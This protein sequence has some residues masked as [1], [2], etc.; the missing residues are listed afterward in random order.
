MENTILSIP[1]SKCTGC[2]ACGN[3]CPKNAITMEPDGE[4]FLFPQVNEALCI[5]CGKCRKVCPVGENPF[6]SENHVEPECYAMWAENEIRAKS[7]SGGVFTL[8]GKWAIENGGAVA[9]AAYTP[10]CYSVAHQI[11]ETEAELAPLRGSKYVQSEMGMTYRQVKE[12]LQADR[13][14]LFTGCPCQ[15][16][17]L[18]KFLGKDYQ[19]L[20][21]VELVC[22]GV[23]A[24]SI[25]AKFVKEQEQVVG[26]KAQSVNMRDKT[27]AEW[28]PAM[29]IH[30]A[31]GKKGEWKRNQSSY[32]RAFLNLLD[33]RPSCGN[34][35][36]AKLPRVADL[37]IADF[38][39]VHRF[40][41]KLDDRKGTSAVLVNNEKGRFL[42]SKIKPAAKLC[43]PVPL[44]H[45]IK[46]NPQIKYSSIHNKKRARFYSLLNEYHYP[47]EKAADYAL[48][49][50]YDIGY[51][52]WWYGLNYGSALTSFAMNRVLNQM[53]KTVLMLDFPVVNG[54]VPEKK[55]ATFTRKF[56]KHYYDEAPLTALDDY[57]KYNKMCDTFLVGSDQLWNWWSNRD[58]KTYFYF[59]DFAD[60]QHKKIAY[61]TSFGHEYVYYPEEMKLKVSYLLQRFDAISLREKSGVQTCN[62]DFNVEG[63][64]AID[65][66]FL[67][68]PRHYEE[69]ADRSGRAGEEKFLLAYI[70]N[71]T[72][73][74]KQQIQYAAEKLGLPYHIILDGQGNFEELNAQM[75]DPNVLSN[76]GIEDW[77]DYMRKAQYVITD[78]YHGFCFSIIFRRPMTV[79]PNRLRGL[80]RFDDLAELTG[81]K[82]R[83]VYSLAEFQNG[84]LWET[85]V[86]FNAVH[87]G[88]ETFKKQSYQWLCHALETRKSPIKS[89]ELLLWKIL[90]HDQRLHRLDRMPQ[91]EGNQQEIQA[92]RKELQELRAMLEAANRGSRFDRVKDL[93]SR[94]RT[95]LRENGFRYTC[96]RFWEKLRNWLGSR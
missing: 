34:C 28:D 35:Q 19:N 56:A 59:L 80:A 36:F 2:E 29:S 91:G 81:L 96:R 64:H 79:L 20:Y 47:F 72:P 13:P 50:K 57:R 33:I 11:A 82:G 89:R 18:Y 93:A 5:D 15:V 94:G 67:C 14:V 86:D 73:E 38:W 76:V 3:A 78:S 87:A 7:S 71:P 45:A 69:A 32:L 88:L 12:I 31:N 61:S 58:V 9:G 1:H 24:Q 65:P 55:P 43:T 49:D 39:D 42:L 62:R 6:V 17:G 30:F 41:P 95:C 74:K 68:D 52:G 46:Y 83:F 44:S 77:L 66:V 25:F 48:N 10:D 26:S 54:S 37:T 90:E 22:H 27:V 84:R 23:P 8:L 53:G 60:N 4:G 63:T 21:T 92:L 16:A 85:P 40:D 70:L 51:V 75:D